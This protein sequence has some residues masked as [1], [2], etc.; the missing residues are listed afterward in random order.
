MNKVVIYAMKKVE[1]Y[2]VG[3]KAC[4]RRCHW[5]EAGMRKNKQ[6]CYPLEEERRRQGEQLMQRP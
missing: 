3:A 6:P 1:S 4:L 2:G 5:S